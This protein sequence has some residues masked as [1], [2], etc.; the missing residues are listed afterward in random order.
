MLNV[1]RHGK[2]LGDRLNQVVDAYASEH[3][4]STK[5]SQEDLDR[6][7][8]STTMFYAAKI[9]RKIRQTSGPKMYLAECMS[10]I[11]ALDQYSKEVD[12]AK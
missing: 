9:L 8:I 12:H 1:M 6:F 3:E 11:E 7:F 2:Q 5:C 4:L 10:L